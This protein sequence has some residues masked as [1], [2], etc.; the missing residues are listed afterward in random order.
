MMKVHD[1]YVSKEEANERD[2]FLIHNVDKN[3]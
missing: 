3:V 1:V 2:E